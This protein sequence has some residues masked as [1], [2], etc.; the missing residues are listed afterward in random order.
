MSRFG[1]FCVSGE[2]LKTFVNSQSKSEQR[3]A[4]SELIATLVQVATLYYE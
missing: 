3:I 4:N 1:A 2:M